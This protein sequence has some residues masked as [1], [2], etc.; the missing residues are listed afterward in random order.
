MKA[1][2]NERNGIMRKGSILVT[3]LIILIVVVY[4]LVKLQI[5]LSIRLK[6]YP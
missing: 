6:G 1:S 3:V 4:I 2:I 5:L